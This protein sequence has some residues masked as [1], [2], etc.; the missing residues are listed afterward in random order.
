MA[1]ITHNLCKP[2][3]LFPAIDVQLPPR[4]PKAVRHVD[5]A[6]DPK[7]PRTIFAVVSLQPTLGF[8]NFVV[9]PNMPLYTGGLVSAGHSELLIA[10]ETTGFSG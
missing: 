4:Y 9:S 3:A 1:G 6:R 2:K 5:I 8:Y 7:H 10:S